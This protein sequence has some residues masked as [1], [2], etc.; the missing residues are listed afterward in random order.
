MEVIIVVRHIGG[1][2]TMMNK[3]INNIIVLV[4]FLILMPFIF[5]FGTFIILLMNTLFWDAIKIWQHWLS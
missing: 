1:K 5:T 2:C 4:I 3:I